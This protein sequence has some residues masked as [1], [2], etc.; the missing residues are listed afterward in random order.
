MEE[1]FDADVIEY[2]LV[3]SC[4]LFLINDLLTPLCENDTMQCY[5]TVR[6]AI[7]PSVISWFIRY[8][9]LLFEVPIVIQ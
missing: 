6:L 3:N 5:G 9:R 8:L 4:I 1:R 2:L 7:S